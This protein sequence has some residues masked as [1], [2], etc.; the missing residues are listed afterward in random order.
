MMLA[1]LVLEW[2]VCH[3]FVIISNCLSYLMKMLRLNRGKEWL[4]SEHST[5]ISFVGYNLFSS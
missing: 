4:Y 2:L 3:L 1:K 5:C